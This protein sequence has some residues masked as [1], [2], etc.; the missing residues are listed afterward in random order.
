MA[1]K[2]L[3][4]NTYSPTNGWFAEES[5]EF[6]LSAASLEY[7]ISILF[8]ENSAFQLLEHS[9]FAMINRNLLAIT[10]EAFDFF[11][12]KNI[13]IETNILNKFK[14]LNLFIKKNINFKPINLDNLNE[15]YNNHDLV[16]WY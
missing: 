2:Y 6:V 9:K 4:I 8:L 13:Y 12:L 5:L 14:N 7:E 15:L 1:K 3:I 11:A 10:L 16:L